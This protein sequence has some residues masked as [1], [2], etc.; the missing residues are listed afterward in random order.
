VRS[1]GVFV[2]T[3]ICCSWAQRA[4]FRYLAGTDP[5]NS[6]GMELSKLLAKL[7]LCYWIFITTTFFVLTECFVCVLP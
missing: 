2:R 3:Q 4:W 6:Y 1:V 5:L 7:S